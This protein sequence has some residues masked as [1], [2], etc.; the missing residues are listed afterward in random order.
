MHNKCNALE[1]SWNHPPTPNPWKNCL[2]QNRPL[3][4]K[5]LGTAVI[6]GIIPYAVLC[7]WFHSLKTILW[8]LPILQHIIFCLFFIFFSFTGD[9]HLGCSKFLL[10]MNNVAMELSVKIFVC[11][12]VCVCL[13]VHFTVCRFIGIIFLCHMVS[14]GFTFEETN[15]FPEWLHYSAV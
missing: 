14:L 8:S 3:V 5:R 6:N 12:C 13:Y 7:I 11:V 4:P 15:R 1:S 10:L 9:G 2:P